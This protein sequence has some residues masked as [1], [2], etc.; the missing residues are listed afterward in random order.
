MSRS[1]PHHLAVLM[2]ACAAVT[3]VAAFV[4]VIENDG[5]PQHAK[6]FKKKKRNGGSSPK[7]REGKAYELRN[8]MN[9]CSR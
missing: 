5:P 4:P 2:L 1:R 9:R 6:G 8:K 7:K 3:E